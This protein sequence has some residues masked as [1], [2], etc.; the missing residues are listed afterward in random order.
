MPGVFLLLGPA[1]INWV[2]SSALK[3][4]ELKPVSLFHYSMLIDLV[5]SL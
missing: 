3:V 4:C 5:V 1:W 2:F